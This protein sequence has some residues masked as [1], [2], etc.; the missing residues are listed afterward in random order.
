MGRRRAGGLRHLFRILQN[1][2]K[3]RSRMRQDG[4]AMAA[5]PGTDKTKMNMQTLNGFNSSADFG[6]GGNGLFNQVFSKNR[7]FVAAVVKRR[8]AAFGGG[9]ANSHSRLSGI[10]VFS[11][12]PGCA[13]GGGGG[14]GSGRTTSRRCCSRD[15]SRRSHPEPRRRRRGLS[16]AGR[17]I[18]QGP[19]DCGHGGVPAGGML[20]QAGP[21]QRGGHEI[22]RILRDFS[23]QQTL[24]MLCRQNLAGMGARSEEAAVG[25]PTFTTRLTRLIGPADR[26]S[27][28]VP[29]SASTQL[30]QQQS[31]LKHEE[32]DLAD[33]QRQL[34]VG[35]ATLEAQLAQL[36]SL[37]GD[38]LRIAVQQNYPNPVLTKLM[39]DLAEAKQKV[40]GFA[41]TTHGESRYG[42]S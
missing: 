40:A 11:H 18:Q 10:E 17:S 20:P 7:V 12:C 22:R 2:D 32:Q 42:E 4:R 29:P 26:S 15:C 19:A 30:E 36:K 13:H 27:N 38:K 35:A 14:A 24:V 16:D 3:F 5:A 41:R 8:R 6:F 28:S 25:Q 21:N 37:T 33:E 39:Q 9:S 31:Q 1:R 23:D 34:E